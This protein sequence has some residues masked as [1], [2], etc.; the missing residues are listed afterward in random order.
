MMTLR[1]LERYWNTK[2]Y[3]RLLDELLADRPED[4]L[5]LRQRLSGALPS[6]ALSLIRL[7]ELDQSHLPLCQ[8]L[9]RTI[10]AAQEADGGWLEPMTTAVCIRAMLCAKGS[11]DA[12]ASGLAYLAALQKSEGAWSDIPIRRMPA[13]ALTSAYILYQLGD[14]AEFRQAVRFADATG[15]FEKNAA[16][17]DEDSRYLWKR[18][19]F[20]CRL[21]VAASS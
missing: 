11:G 6:A 2:S 20:K 10:L 13:D 12:V 7:E 14:S 19:S 4:M 3:A 1:Q 8:E 5:I 9:I 21:D 16:R 17:L 15:W 18:A